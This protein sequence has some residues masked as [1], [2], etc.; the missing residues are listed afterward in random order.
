[1]R[2]FARRLLCHVQRLGNDTTPDNNNKYRF[3]KCTLVT[4]VCHETT[5]FAEEAGAEINAPDKN[6]RVYIAINQACVDGWVV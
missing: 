4:H 6:A 2:L 5:T 3:G 1:M